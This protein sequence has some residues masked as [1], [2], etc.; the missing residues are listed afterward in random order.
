MAGKMIT[1]EDIEAKIEE[2]TDWRRVS[3]D[4]S[5]KGFALYGF[6]DRKMF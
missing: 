6:Y 1:F 4:E 2:E 3:R 5:A